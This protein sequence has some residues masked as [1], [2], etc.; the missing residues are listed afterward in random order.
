MEAYCDQ[1]ATL[2]HGGEDVVLLAISADAPEEQAAWAKDEDF[3]FT[4]LSDSGIPVGTAYGA[5][6]PTRGIDNR[7]VFIIDTAGTIQHVIAPFREIDPTAYV[8]LQ[9]AI[10]RIARPM[11]Q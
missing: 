11:Q 6:L 2:F 7:T 9:E 1:Y 8:D 4:F 3:P 5:A 10:D